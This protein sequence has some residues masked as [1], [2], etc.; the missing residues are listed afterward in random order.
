[1]K[2]LSLLKSSPGWNPVTG[3]SI[4]I[5]PLGIVLSSC[6]P[7]LIHPPDKV[8][9]QALNLT[10][11]SPAAVAANI[12]LNMEAY[13]SNGN[14]LTGTMPNQGNWNMNTTAFPGAG[15]Y[16]GLTSTLT[17]TNVCTGTTIF[18]AA[19]AAVCESGSTVSP[20]GAANILSGLE[21]WDA[22]GTKITGTM[23]N[24]GALNA[25]NAFPGSGYYNG[26]VNNAPTASQ[27]ASGNTILGVSG[28]F[29]GTFALNTGSNALRDA[30]VLVVPQLA[31]QTT[32][33]Q[34]TLNS[35]VATYGSSNLPTTGGYNYRDIPDATKDD[36]GY[37]G[38][39]CAYALRPGTNC[40]IAQA[41]LAARIA[42]CATQNPSTS[43]WNGAAQCSQGQ[44]MWQLV[45][46]NGANQ[47]VWKDQRTGLI[48]SSYVSAGINWCQASGNTQNAPVTFT[49]AYNNAAGTPITGNGTLGS[50]SGGSSSLGETITVTFTNATTFSVSG[51]GG[52]GGC[53]G[54]SITSGGLTT[55]A[56]S[57]VTWSRAG[58]CSFTITQGAVNYAANDKQILTSV[59]AASY[60][61]APGAG[62]LLQPA[63]PVSFCAEAAGVNAPAGENWGT[64]TYL[65]A[66]GALGANSTPSVRWRLPTIHDYEQA[67]ING[68]RQVFPDMGIAG[69]NRPVI[70]GSPGATN[71]EWS[72]SLYSSFRGVSWVFYGGDGYVGGNLRGTS[73][74]VRCV[75]R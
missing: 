5:C 48:W 67:E 68:I 29:T 52:A 3:L 50:I 63:S 6:V 71:Y 23:T 21:A 38:T 60:S 15:Y 64:G 45:T 34:L 35:E 57:T 53:Q 26:T 20:A 44:G 33:S 30:G 73:Y 66:K 41:T 51:T 49:Q 24:Q 59:A 54:G 17:T 65:A 8:S 62:S 42:D 40:G 27:I 19:G 70:D 43:T 25:Q 46:R 56:G 2:F 58:F 28:S 13:D 12:L 61:C 11:L 18:G 37:N 32:S 31:G 72:A 4:F 16:S 22:T 7:E 47:E 9:A 55:T 74:P 75:G 36:E 14:V 1:M 39:T 69:T 10:P